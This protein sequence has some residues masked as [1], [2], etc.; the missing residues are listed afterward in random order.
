MQLGPHERQ[1]LAG[2]KVVLGLLSVEVSDQVVWCVAEPARRKDFASGLKASNRAFLLL[3][4]GRSLLL[5]EPCVECCDVV[6]KSVV[7]KE[8]GDSFHLFLLICLELFVAT[9]HHG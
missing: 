3:L 1:V 2:G 8:P 5:H 4:A 6:G 7:S 9:G